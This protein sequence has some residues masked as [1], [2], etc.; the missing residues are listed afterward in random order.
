MDLLESDRIDTLQVNVGKLCNQA[1]LH[2]HVEAGPLRREIMPRKI[3]DAVLA[4]LKRHRIPNLDITGGAPE[5]NPRFDYLV[6]QAEG[7]GKHVMVRSNLTVYFEEGKGY[8]PE[9]FRRHHVEVIASLPCYLEENTDSQRGSGVFEKSVQALRLL[10]A[11]GYGQAEPSLIL[12]LVYNPV[13]AYLPPPQVELEA[14]YRRELESRYGIVFNRLYVLANM[15]VGRFQHSLLRSGEH[16]QYMQKLRDAF[17]PAT[18]D[19]LMCRSLISVGWD[20]TLYDCDFNQ[21]LNLSVNHGA[22]ATIFDFDMD[23]LARRRICVGEHCYACTAGA[24]SSCGG[25]LA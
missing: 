19:G 14:D 11:A 12:N 17:N 21:M 6:E 22:P 23:Q 3:V 25:A 15:P 7:M 20:G 10:N 24:G 13:G 8:L 5:M 1:C 18:V 4:V 2:C 9:F 16:G